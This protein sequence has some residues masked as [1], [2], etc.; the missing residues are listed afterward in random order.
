ML[1]ISV[2]FVVKKGATLFYPNYGHFKLLIKN[3]GNI[4]IFFVLD[5]RIL[6][7]DAVDVRY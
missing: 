3:I 6:Y 2:I 7:Y 4:R 5:E 1:R